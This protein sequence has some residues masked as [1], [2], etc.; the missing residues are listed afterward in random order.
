MNELQQNECNRHSKE[1][2]IAVCLDSN[3]DHTNAYCCV[4]CLFDHYPVCRQEFIVSFDSLRKTLSVSPEITDYKNSLSDLFVAYEGDIHPK[5]EKLKSILSNFENSEREDFPES[6]LQTDLI[7]LR[8]CFEKSWDAENKKLVLRESPHF[9]A[10]LKEACDDFKA[11]VSYLFEGNF[12]NEARDLAEKKK[13]KSISQE[14]PVARK[15][16]F[17]SLKFFMATKT[18]IYKFS[19]GAKLDI[20]DTERMMV[21]YEANSDFTVAITHSYRKIN[22]RLKHSLFP[23]REVLIFYLVP[24]DYVGFYTLQTPPK[25]MCDNL[26]F[27]KFEAVNLTGTKLLTEKG[28]TFVFDQSKKKFGLFIQEKEVSSEEINT[29]KADVEYVLLINFKNKEANNVYFYIQ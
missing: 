28:M 23:K 13:I 17:E 1:N 25:N 14:G 12:V 2:L 19:G 16:E 15:S 22:L 3:C 18:E 20:L 21:K 29:I 7:L 10:E 9:L 6:L 11:R 5:F 8:N 4:K 26:S 27:L 24:K